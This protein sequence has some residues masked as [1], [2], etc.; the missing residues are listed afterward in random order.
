M[1]MRTLRD[2]LKNKKAL[3]KLL[4]DGEVDMDKFL[5]DLSYYD[6]LE[7]LQIRLVRLQK[8]IVTEGKRIAIVFEGRDSSGKGGTIR[9]F[10][11][12]LNPREM[13]VVA[14]TKPNDKELGQWYFQRYIKQL[15]NR[16]EIVF[17]D[18]SWYNRAV[19]EP[20][21][22]F[23]TKDQYDHFMGQVN[24]FERMLIDD[25][26][27]LLK[28]WLEIDKEEQL[29]RFEARKEDPLKQWKL[30]PIDSQALDLW[31]I[32]SRYIDSMLQSTR[33]YVDWNIVNANSKKS[34]RIEC[35]EKVLAIL[36]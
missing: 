34:A 20:V 28:F 32:Y 3:N 11:E 22:G 29:K 24:D 31:P 7:Q 6:C 2:L 10:I 26:I 15:P 8:K 13:R 25:G 30:S 1:V 14:L 35:I 5:K 19:V 17:F 27:I 16:G 12:H 33:E 18:R 23:C 9:R 4:E 36:E 21:N